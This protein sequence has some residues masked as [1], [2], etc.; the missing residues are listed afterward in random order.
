MNERS[1]RGDGAGTTGSLRFPAR[2]TGAMLVLVGLVH[3]LA[4]GALLRTA[5]IGYGYVLRVGFDPKPGA[6]S[7]VRGVGLALIA[8]GAHLL[9]HGGIVPRGRK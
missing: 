7:R 2:L 3:L 4:P 5:R 6:S 8:A 9:Y 1:G